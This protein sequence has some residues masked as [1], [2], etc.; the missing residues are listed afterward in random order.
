MVAIDFN[1]HI[2]VIFLSTYLLALSDMCL[3]NIKCALPNFDFMPSIS[4]IIR[5]LLDI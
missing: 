2:L 4:P 3:K 1:H 5:L